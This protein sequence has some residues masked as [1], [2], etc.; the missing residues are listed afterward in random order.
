MALAARSTGG[1][2]ATVEVMYR[3]YRGPLV[4]THKSIYDWFPPAIN[5]WGT[6]HPVPDMASPLLAEE[7]GPLI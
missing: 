7:E 1:L 6:T 4:T 2:E 3:G 5:S